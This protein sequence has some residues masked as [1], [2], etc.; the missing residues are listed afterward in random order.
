MHR[1]HVVHLG[2]Q[3]ADGQPLCYHHPPAQP[4]V[5]SWLSS[6]VNRHSTKN[7]YITVIQSYRT[8][9]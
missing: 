8:T 6:A 5:M 9:S 7:Q 4:D 2:V 1:L 3:L